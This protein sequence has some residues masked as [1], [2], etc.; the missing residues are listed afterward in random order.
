MVRTGAAQT[1]LQFD[2]GCGRR[3]C[4]YNSIV[5]FEISV[6]TERIKNSVTLEKGGVLDVVY[7]VEMKGMPLERCH[8]TVNI[9]PLK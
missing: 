3:I 8:L 9:K 2:G 6:V 1:T 5:P 7:C 4:S